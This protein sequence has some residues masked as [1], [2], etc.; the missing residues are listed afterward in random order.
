MF[1]QAIKITKVQQ[2]LYDSWSEYNMLTINFILAWFE[3]HVRRGTSKRWRTFGSNI[4][5]I[6]TQNKNIK[7][8]E[9]DDTSRFRIFANQLKASLMWS[10][11]KSR[12]NSKIF[13]NNKDYNLNLLSFLL[14]PL[15]FGDSYVEYVSLYPVSNLCLN[16]GRCKGY[17]KSMQSS[18]NKE[19]NLWCTATGA[20]PVEEI[21]LSYRSGRVGNLP[22]LWIYRT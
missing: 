8:S 20:R 16:F 12:I 9:N 22:I 14:S 1:L 15:C 17:E 18:N 11:N 3:K 13:I 19:I 2:I 7:T 6:Y 4:L 21:S 10:R 5:K